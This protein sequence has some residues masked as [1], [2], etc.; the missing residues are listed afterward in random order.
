MSR[1]GARDGAGRDLIVCGIHAVRQVLA[2][3]PE[4]ALELWIETGPPNPRLR[5]LLK[6]AAQ[7]GLAVQRAAARTLDRLAAGVRHQGTVLR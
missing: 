7:H 6:L 4:R 3:A 1:R 5:D 2:D